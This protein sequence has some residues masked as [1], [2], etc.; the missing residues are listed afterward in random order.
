[1]GP[2]SP[3]PCL[4]HPRFV[5]SFHSLL[6]SSPKAGRCASDG[7]SESKERDDGE[8]AGRGEERR[9]D[10]HLSLYLLII[11]DVILLLYDGHV[12]RIWILLLLSLLTFS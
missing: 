9:H 3:L 1:M 10:H 8:A 2:L 5:C 11:S 7:M 4:R 6:T 12:V